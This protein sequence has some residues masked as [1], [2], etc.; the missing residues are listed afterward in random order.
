MNR[1]EFPE[2]DA[3]E[4]ESSE[5]DAETPWSRAAEP[6]GLMAFAQF[7]MKQSYVSALIVMMVGHHLHACALRF[8][9]LLDVSLIYYNCKTRVDSSLTTDR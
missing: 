8:I 3:D 1:S 4:E 2:E 6:R 5:G 9:L 7:I